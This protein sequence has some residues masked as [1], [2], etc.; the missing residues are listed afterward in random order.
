M[1]ES[2]I[3]GSIRE[4]TTGPSSILARRVIYTLCAIEALCLSAAALVLLTHESDPATA[5]IDVFAAVVL[6]VFGMA[7]ILPAYSRAKRGKS[8]APAYAL[9]AVPLLTVFGLV[10]T[11]A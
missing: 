11:L 1:S 2:G 4:Q 9:I 3:E 6:I 5:G 10:A 7:F 8:L